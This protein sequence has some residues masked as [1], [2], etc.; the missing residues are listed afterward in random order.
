MSTNIII[1]NPYNQVYWICCGIVLISLITSTNMSTNT[2][3]SP[4]KTCAALFAHKHDTEEKM[5]S[6]AH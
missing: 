3:M 6:T 5:E 2:V 1:I 4:E